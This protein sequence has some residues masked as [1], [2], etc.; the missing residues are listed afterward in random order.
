M[1][2]KLIEGKNG[3]YSSKRFVFIISSISAIVGFFYSIQ[4]VATVSPELIPQILSYFL[5]YCSFIG[6]FVT[7]EM[8]NSIFKSY[9]KN[10]KKNENN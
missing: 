3:K 2:S 4:K 5:I 8:I 10:K 6:G 7:L 1:L 9:F